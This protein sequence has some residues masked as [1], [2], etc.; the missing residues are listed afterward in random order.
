[1][2]DEPHAIL[3]CESEPQL[4]EL[5]EKWWSDPSMD[6][7]RRKYLTEDM[8]DRDVMRTLMRRP[9]AHNVMGWYIYHVLKIFDEVEMYEPPRSLFTND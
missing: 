1:M 3:R 2:E 5:R 6:L 4:M 9:E 7:V 8:D